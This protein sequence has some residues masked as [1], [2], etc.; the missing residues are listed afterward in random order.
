M[1]FTIH[2]SAVAWNM[3]YQN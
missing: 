2:L 3:N 1:G